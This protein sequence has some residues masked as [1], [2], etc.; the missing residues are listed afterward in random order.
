[1]LYT[2]PFALL[3]FHSIGMDSFNAGGTQIEILSS[4]FNCDS[5]IEYILTVNDTPTVSI[6]IGD[7]TICMDSSIF[8]YAS[9]ADN[10]SWDGNITNNDYNILL[11]N[12]IYTV[13]GIDT[14]NCRH[15]VQ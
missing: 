8:I 10:Y 11:D 15:Q 1:M 6:N 9:G 3:I 14:N 12:G 13:I 7:A 4:S 5:V 2:T